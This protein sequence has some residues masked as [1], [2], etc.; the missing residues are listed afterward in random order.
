M[1]PPETRDQ[2]SL[3]SFVTS[4]LA[5]GFRSV[6]E[7]GRR[8][9]GPLHQALRQFTSA[10]EMEV[11]IRDAW[12]YLHPTTHVD[13]IP[14][15]FHRT[16]DGYV[17]L[18]EDGDPSMAWQSWDAISE[19]IEKWAIEAQGIGTE[20]DPGFDPD[21]YFRGLRAGLATIDLSTF[22]LR[23]WKWYELRATKGDKVLK[24][25]QGDVRGYMYM[26]DRPRLPA[27]TLGEARAE[28]RL[29]QQRHLDRQLT[30]VGQPGGI[31]FIAFAWT[32]PAGINLLI[33]GLERDDEG[34]LIVSVYQA[35]RTDREILMLRA[36]PDAVPL[37]GKAVVVFG[38]GAV[39]SHVADL[40]ARS[41]VGQL[42]L[43]DREVLRPGDIVRHRSRFTGYSKVVSTAVTIEEGAPWTS[44][45]P[46]SEAPWA[47]SLLAE[48]VA[49]CDL[50]LDAT[51]L[52]TFSAQLSTLCADR[53]IPMVSVAL[54]RHG[55]VGRVRVQARNPADLIFDRTEPRYAEIPSDGHEAEVAY[56]TGCSAPIAQAPPASVAAVAATAARWAVEVLTGRNDDDCDVIDVYRPLDAPPFAEVG[57]LIYP[58]Q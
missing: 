27:K 8:W 4:L 13:G 5:A 57:T 45:I 1:P 40:L 31:S 53:T 58:R 30:T 50:V 51:G 48:A 23:D 17:C 55:D 52:K 36:G 44:V 35:A 54:Y 47:P 22:R 14:T 28:L 39:G 29:K 43:L 3:D 15:G 34:E 56:E 6:D 2:A 21:V 24:I 37:S 10:D 25:G 19:R 38:V 16:T 33:L 41:G 20:T 7:D 9:R 46:R 49:G 42:N 32:T 18:W 11:R 12:P 26:R